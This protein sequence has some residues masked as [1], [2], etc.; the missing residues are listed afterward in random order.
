MADVA[1]GVVGVVIYVVLLLLVLL[2][3]MVVVW[4]FRWWCRCCIDGS[5]IAVSVVVV[6][7]VAVPLE[8]VMLVLGACLCQLCS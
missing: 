4:G 1:V 3:A 2:V 7:V 5:Y 8:A 6:V